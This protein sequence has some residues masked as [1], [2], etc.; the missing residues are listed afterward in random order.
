MFESIINEAKTNLHLVMED[1]TL[2]PAD[3]LMVRFID[4]PDSLSREETID[5]FM[6]SF[7]LDLHTTVAFFQGK[8]FIPE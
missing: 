4:D 8:D 6:E 1:E 2:L 5:L 3:R 7:G